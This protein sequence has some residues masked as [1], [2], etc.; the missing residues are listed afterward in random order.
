MEGSENYRIAMKLLLITE[1]TLYLKDISLNLTKQ[2][3]TIFIFSST[4]IKFCQ[5]NT[6][7]ANNDLLYLVYKQHDS[8][9]TN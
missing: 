3:N 1:T 5:N 8:E 7:I 6:P 4:P 9:G 2:T